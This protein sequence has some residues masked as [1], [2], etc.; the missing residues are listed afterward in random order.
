MYEKSIKKTR[1]SPVVS[2]SNVLLGGLTGPLTF[3]QIG[4]SL[5]DRDVV[6]EKIPDLL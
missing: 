3:M 5:P 2:V 6:K 4:H 1:T